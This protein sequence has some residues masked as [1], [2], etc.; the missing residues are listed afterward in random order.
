MTKNSISS[1]N[2]KK[3]KAVETDIINAFR[4]ATISVVE[5]S[6]S[7]CNRPN[8]LMGVD[9]VDKY[10]ITHQ[11]VIEAVSDTVTIEMDACLAFSESCLLDKSDRELGLIDS[12]TGSDGFHL[13]YDVYSENHSYVT[14]HNKNKLG[15]F[16]HALA[17]TLSVDVQAIF[18]VT[19]AQPANANQSSVQF[20][21]FCF[22]L[23]TL[24]NI[25][26]GEVN[27][28]NFNL[29]KQIETVNKAAIE[30]SLV[31]FRTLMDKMSF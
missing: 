5:T 18:G 8:V 21:F 14:V 26:T 22:V 15:S 10:S 28:T 4:T 12:I 2:L 6:I 23:E 25:L 20:Q 1:E 13:D 19:Y 9:G 27:T 3:F 24:N 11:V 29:L 30:K 16:A 31:D 7:F 17:R